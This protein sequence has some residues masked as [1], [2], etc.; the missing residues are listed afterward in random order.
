M[1]SYGRRAWSLRIRP[2]TDSAALGILNVRDVPHERP[3]GA[4]GAFLAGTVT[5][6]RSGLP[7]GTGGA[8][9]LLSD[10]LIATGIA[11][12][13]QLPAPDFRVMPTYV[14]ARYLLTAGALQAMYGERRTTS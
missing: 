13:P 8:L 3:L 7:A 14:A 6:L 12:L 10:T 4:D 2:A 1:L 9:F 5:A 11:G